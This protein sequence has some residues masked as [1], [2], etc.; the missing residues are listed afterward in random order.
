MSV[1]EAVAQIDQEVAE[2][3][4]RGVCGC[5]CGKQLPVR[6]NARKLFV[7]K[8]HGQRAYRQRVHAACEAAGLPCRVSLQQV[9]ASNGTRDGNG[10]RHSARNTVQT[11]SKP[12]GLQVSFWKAVDVLAAALQHRA[13]YSETRARRWAVQLLAPALSDL[14]RQQLADRTGYTAAGQTREAA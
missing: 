14:Q 10:D 13:G 6:R 12:S 7:D 3:V 8:T 2:R 9:R 5:G 4:E 11:R 1:I